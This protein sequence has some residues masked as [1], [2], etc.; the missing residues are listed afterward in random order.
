MP[1]NAVGDKAQW[2]AVSLQHKL[3]QLHF[4]YS[5]FLN[6]IIVQGPYLFRIPNSRSYEC[7]DTIR[8]MPRVFCHGMEKPSA[9]PLPQPVSTI[10]PV[11]S[12]SHYLLR[13]KVK[14]KR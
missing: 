6:W 2:E 13:F 10:L 9:L 7:Y 14:W 4:I 1:R 12:D 11:I 8:Q 5:P 3:N